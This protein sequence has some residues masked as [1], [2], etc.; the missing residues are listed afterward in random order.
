[1]GEMADDFSPG[2]RCA[3][4][5]EDPN[6]NELHTYDEWLTLG[7]VVRRGEKSPTRNQE[8]IALFWGSQ[9]K[10]MYGES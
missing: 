8:G 1:M 3:Y 2:G 6:E 7:F 9:V 4:E 5:P 10:S